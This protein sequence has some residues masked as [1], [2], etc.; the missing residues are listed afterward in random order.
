MSN[1]DKSCFETSQSKWRQIKISG[2][3]IIRTRQPSKRNLTM[4]ANDGPQI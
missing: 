4:T 3:L 2:L 1:E